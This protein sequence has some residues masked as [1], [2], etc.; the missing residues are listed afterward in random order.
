[1]NIGGVRCL[2]RLGT[3]VGGFDIDVLAVILGRLVRPQGFD[4]FDLLVQQCT[5]CLRVGAV[6]ADL[7]EEPTRSHA[8]YEPA[9]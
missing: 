6:V 8:E 7:L 5:P 1:M 9:P 4:C 3:E 2:H